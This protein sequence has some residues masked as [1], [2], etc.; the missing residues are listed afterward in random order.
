MVPLLHEG[1]QSY[2]EGCP[3]LVSY[4]DCSLLW[5]T[6]F[7]FHFRNAMQKPSSIPWAWLRLG[8]WGSLYRPGSCCSIPDCAKNLLPFHSSGWSGKLRTP[9]F[10]NH[11]EYMIHCISTCFF[12]CIVF[13]LVYILSLPLF[14]K[15]TTPTQSSLPPKSLKPLV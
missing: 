8:I 12:N 10:R 1:H 15:K 14:V 2:L 7:C 5:L 13:C 9:T 4:V 11:L 6:Q 3:S